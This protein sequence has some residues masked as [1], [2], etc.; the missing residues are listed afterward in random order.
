MCWA[1]ASSITLASSLN[2]WSYVI[3][4]IW[5]L[6]AVFF[7]IYR[8]CTLV[9]IFFSLAEAALFRFLIDKVWRRIP[10]INE[11]FFLW[12]I[13]LFNVAIGAFCSVLHLI[14]GEG[15]IPVRKVM[16]VDLGSYPDPDFRLKM[17][18]IL[19]G[20]GTAVILFS[21][22]ARTVSA[23]KI[24]NMESDC[25]DQ[26]RQPRRVLNNRTRNA[27]LVTGSTQI[28][29]AI[30][31]IILMLPSIVF[32][33]IMD[34]TKYG[35]HSLETVF[36]LLRL[37]AAS[38]ILPA[39]IYSRNSALRAHLKSRLEEFCYSIIFFVKVQ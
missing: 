39:I 3:G 35:L 10:P 8:F 17:P 36:D 6:P 2:V 30:L 32:S 4:P 37:V 13:T 14:S 26:V 27:E 33:V 21:N 24:I 11:D 18:L 29:F 1:I 12:F 15:A 16:G 23:S 22:V 5:R 9:H 28:L 25:P 31:G 19:L 38:V 20:L 34:R 7:Y